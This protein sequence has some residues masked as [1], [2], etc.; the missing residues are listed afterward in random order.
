MRRFTGSKLVVASHNE[1]KVS[2]I[3]AL[4]APYG[5]ETASAGE[6][7]LPVPEETGTIS[8]PSSFIRNTFG[9]CRS[10]SVSP[11]NTTHFRPNRAQTVAVATPC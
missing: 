9:F 4:L 3:R 2:E 11:I 6:L 5:I 7:D 1:G 10:T 8:A